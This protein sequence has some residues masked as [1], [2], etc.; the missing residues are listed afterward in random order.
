MVGKT[1]IWALESQVRQVSRDDA[2][3]T[4]SLP[5]VL[6]SIVANKL[7]VEGICADLLCRNS[8]KTMHTLRP[9]RQRRRLC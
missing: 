4:C 8:S 5:S 3:N 7:D 6:Y 2:E 1:F 9:E